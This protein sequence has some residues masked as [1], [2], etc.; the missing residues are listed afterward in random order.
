MVDELVR[1]D[2]YVQSIQ[3]ILLFFFISVAAR[4]KNLN[5]NHIELKMLT[6]IYNRLS[7]ALLIARIALAAGLNKWQVHGLTYSSN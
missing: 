7:I 3:S 5:C 2:F 6:M 4:E 1:H